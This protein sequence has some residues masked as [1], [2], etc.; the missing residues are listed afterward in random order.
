MIKMDL[1][2]DEVKVDSCYA[3]SMK[4]A[5]E[6]MDSLAGFYD[7]N[8]ACIDYWFKDLKRFSEPQ[9]VRLHFDLSNYQTKCRVLFNEITQF[10]G[11]DYDIIDNTVVFDANISGTIGVKILG[12][13]DIIN[14]HFECSSIEE[15]LIEWLETLEK[16]NKIDKEYGNSPTW[17]PNAI[18]FI[19]SLINY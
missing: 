16:T 8:E 7:Q 2:F 18:E 9:S 12:Y 17:H 19:K 4:E 6:I 5:F 14:G 1:Y 10:Y 11:Y 3:S 13:N 15:A